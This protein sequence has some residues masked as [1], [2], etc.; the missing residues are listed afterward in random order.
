[1]PSGVDVGQRS[2]TVRRSNLG[3]IVRGLHERRPA[4]A[5]RARARRRADAQRDPRA[6]RRAGRQR[7]ASEEPRR[8]AGHAGPSVAGRAPQSRRGRRCSPSRSSSTRW[9]RRSSGSA[10][11]SSRRIRVDRPR[12][13]SRV[14]DGRGR[15]R[16]ARRPRCGRRRC[17]DRCR[18]RRRRRRR[19]A[20]ERRGRRDGAEPRLARRPARRAAGGGAAAWTC[21]RGRATRRTSA[22]SPSTG[23]GRR[24]AW[25]T[26]CYVSGEVGVGGGI[27]V[28]GSP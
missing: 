27:I 22:C 4:V 23:A 2:E 26:S 18:R 16:R 24:S 13:H 25:M 17:R 11:T 20:P 8:A 6:G 9:R 3:A 7:L 19:R 28:G 1:M 12:G 10:A 21:R 5:L 14:D 15:P